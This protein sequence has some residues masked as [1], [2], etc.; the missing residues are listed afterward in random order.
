M[1]KHSPSVFFHR[2]PIC[3]DTDTTEKARSLFLKS[4]LNLTGAWVTV[5]KY[6]QALCFAGEG[7]CIECKYA[8]IPFQLANDI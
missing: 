5:S 6:G 8:H 3:I 7:M 4:I 1:C 2:C